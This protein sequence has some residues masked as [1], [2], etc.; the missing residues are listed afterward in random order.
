M[1]SIT[2]YCDLKREIMDLEINL[3]I[4]LYIKHTYMCRFIADKDREV[5]NY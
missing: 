1:K 5:W 2:S 3:Y 4:Y